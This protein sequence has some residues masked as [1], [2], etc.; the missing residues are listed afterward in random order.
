M[1][2][3][4]LVRPCA[5]CPFKNDKPFFLPTE[6]RK[7][8]VDGLRHDQTFTCHNTID[9]NAWHEADEFVPD[10]KNQHCAGALIVMWKSGELWNN[11]LFRL[12]V[13]AFG[14]D[15]TRLD[16]AA[17]VF[18]NLDEFI[19]SDG[20]KNYEQDQGAGGTGVSPGQKP[21]GENQ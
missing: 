11:F 20:D 5:T 8:I 2:K 3:F 13:I 1:C 19:G 6:R 4:S 18:D 21:V 12:A 7:E 17:P 16:L 9:Y 14:F 10:D 15:P